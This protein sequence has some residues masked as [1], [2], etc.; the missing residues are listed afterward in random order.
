MAEAG[1]KQ[2]DV[3]DAA[4]R[5]DRSSAKAKS[6]SMSAARRFPAKTWPPSIAAILDVD[7]A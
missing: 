4:R 2:A 7:A 6:A 1:M 3:I 5:R